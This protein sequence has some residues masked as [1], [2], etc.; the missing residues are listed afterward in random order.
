MESLEDS[1]KQQVEYKDGKLFWKACYNPASIGKE[2]GWLGNRGYRA[3]KIGSKMLLTHRVIWF[4]HHNSWPTEDKMIDHIN[5]NKLDNRLENLRLATRSQ[6]GA[7][8]KEHKNNTSGYRGVH[9]VKED[10]NWRANIKV[11][12]KIKSLG[13]Y[14]T[15]EE[16]SEVYELAADLLFGEYKRGGL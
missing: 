14:K 2:C 3:F 10:K 13:R 6:N 9:W 15:A 5:G 12:N 8:R 1:L 7:N 4:L 16:A 11:N